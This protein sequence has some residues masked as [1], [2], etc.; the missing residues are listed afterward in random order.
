MDWSF[1]SLLNVK[2]CPQMNSLEFA[3][4]MFAWIAFPVPVEESVVVLCCLFACVGGSGTECLKGVAG[5]QKK[6]GTLSF[7]WWLGGA[8]QRLPWMQQGVGDVDVEVERGRWEK[9]DEGGRE[10]VG[11]CYVPL[12]LVKPTMTVVE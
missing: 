8:T 6:G 2:S 12:P 1:G 4:S 3:L 11:L 10:N 7:G 9:R 5:D